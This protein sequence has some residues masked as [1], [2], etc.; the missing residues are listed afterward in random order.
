MAFNPANLTVQ[1]ASWSHDASTSM[2]WN[3]TTSDNL[4]DVQATGY[5]TDIRYFRNG[6]WL[7]VTA[8]D[9][10]AMYTIWAVDSS[11][12]GLGLTRLALVS[13][14]VNNVYGP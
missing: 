12:P 8:N 9:G 14:F 3:Y 7:R 11:T 5:F 6:E 4:S 1:Q 13:S 10:S 2:V